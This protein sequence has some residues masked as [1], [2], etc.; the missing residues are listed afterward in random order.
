MDV[1]QLLISGELRY[2][3]EGDAQTE[4]SSYKC[5]N[6]FIDIPH[7]VVEGTRCVTTS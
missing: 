2:G 1:N 7:D 4:K 5:D 6:T 3:S